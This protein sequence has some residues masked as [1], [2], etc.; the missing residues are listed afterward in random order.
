MSYPR[1]A[2]PDAIAA[3]ELNVYPNPFSDN[4]V[5]D[6]SVNEPTDFIVSLYDIEGRSV[7]LQQTGLIQN[8]ALVELNL[9]ALNAGTYIIVVQSERELLR[10]VLIKY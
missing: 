2:E 9:S 5:L 1:F 8:D 6:L 7:F 3:A 10:K 4:I